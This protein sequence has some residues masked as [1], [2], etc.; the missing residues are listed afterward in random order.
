M[1]VC[2]MIRKDSKDVS[3]WWAFHKH[4]FLK[5]VSMG[6]PR[7]M[8]EFEIFFFFFY[9]PEFLSP[10]CQFM[11]K[12]NIQYRW[13]GREKGVM[14]GQVMN[15]F[16]PQWTPAI[17]HVCQSVLKINTRGNYI[18]KRRDWG[19]KHR[20]Q[21]KMALEQGLGHGKD[22][23]FKTINTSGSR[24]QA[25]ISIQYR[26]RCVIIYNRSLSQFLWVFCLLFF[27]NIWRTTYRI[28]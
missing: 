2:M 15:T 13:Q 8:S 16:P 18:E 21:G 19:V 23:M 20:V 11:N 24:T 1:Q 5:Q 28:I 14:N 9:I 10:S 26:R 3:Q 27:F 6:Y 4:C 22:F 25:H 17:S 7:D 12:E